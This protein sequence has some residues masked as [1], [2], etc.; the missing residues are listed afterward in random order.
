MVLSCSLVGGEAAACGSRQAAGRGAGDGRGTLAHVRSRQRRRFHCPSL[1]YSAPYCPPSPHG[2]P[3][4]P[5]SAEQRGPHALRHL[6]QHPRGVSPM[7]RCRRRRRRR[8]RRLARLQSAARA[9]GPTD[10]GPAPARMLR[11]APRHPRRRPPVL[12]RIKN[13]VFV[14]RSRPGPEPCWEPLGHIRL[15]PFRVSWYLRR[16]RPGR[17]PDGPGPGHRAVAGAQR[18]PGLQ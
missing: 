7:L 16:V 1:L 3:P 14:L 8:R 9:V 2:P 10:G 15:G 11:R 6:P 13:V 17:Q 12:L 18:Y 4:P 5:P